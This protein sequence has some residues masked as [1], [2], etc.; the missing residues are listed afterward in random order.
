MNRNTNRQK[1]QHPIKLLARYSILALLLLSFL[2]PLI[3]GLGVIKISAAEDI[4]VY[5][6]GGVIV[7]TQSGTYAIKQTASKPILSITVSGDIDVTLILQDVQIDNTTNTKFSATTAT[8]LFVNGT[9]TSYDTA[10]AAL[11]FG[12]E[13][14]GYQQGTVRETD[15]GSEVI[16][17]EQIGEPD[18]STT[19][20]EGYTQVYKQGNTYYYTQTTTTT[21]TTRYKVQENAA[22][23]VS[24]SR[25]VPTAPLLVTDG[26]TAK[27]QMNGS[28]SFKAGLNKQQCSIVYSK[29]SA[30]EKE[31]EVVETT[32]VTKCYRGGKNQTNLREYSGTV[33]RVTYPQTSS[34]TEENDVGNVTESDVVVGAVTNSTFTAS[35]GSSAYAGIQVD[36]DATLYLS[37]AA[38]SSCYAQGGWFYDGNNNRTDSLLNDSDTRPGGSSQNQSGAAGIGGGAGYNSNNFTSA[39]TVGAAGTLIFES[40][41]FEAR[42]G[43]QAAGI[44]GAVNSPATATSITINGGTV[45]ARGG[46][47][48]AGIGDGDTI[49][50]SSS[51]RG[52][53][54]T[55]ASS[56]DRYTI[57]VNGGTVEA[58]GGVSSAG[59]G[60]SDEISHG[61]GGG[62]TAYSMMEINLMGGHITVRSGYPDNNYTTADVTTL[63]AAI[64][65]GESTNMFN[66]SITVAADAKLDAASFSKYAISNIG[67]N[68]DAVPVVVL[69]SSGRLVLLDFSDQYGEAAEGRIFSLYPAIKVTL[70]DG[71]SHP[72]L[73]I[74]DR[75]Y[76]E[77][78]K[79]SHTFRECI[80]EGTTVTITDKIYVS[81]GTENKY[82]N[83]DDPGDVLIWDDH[84]LA[85]AYDTSD[86]LFTYHV[87]NYFKAIAVTMPS[88]EDVEYNGQYV[89]VI[90]DDDGDISVVVGLDATNQG[91]ISG[92][93]DS[94]KDFSIKLDS[95]STDLT[96]I[97]V[98]A[99]PAAGSIDSQ[100][101]YI[102]DDD[103]ILYGYDLYL[104]AGTTVATIT[105]YL[106]KGTA[107]YISDSGDVNIVNGQ[108]ITI[109]GLTP[110]KEVTVRLRKQD[111][112]ASAIAYAITLHVRTAYELLL[113][114]LDKAYDGNTANVD[115]DAVKLVYPG[116]T[117]EVTEVTLTDD[118]KEELLL[119]YRRGATALDGAPKDVGTYTLDATYFP[120]N[121]PWQ[122]NGSVDFTIRKRE[123][124]IDGI[125]KWFVY[126]T[127]GELADFDQSI[128]DT[129]EIYLT[130]VV[131]GETVGVTLQ[132][133][134][135]DKAVG[136]S[137][138]KIRLTN[139]TLVGDA[140]VIANYTIQPTILVP[141]QIL[142]DMDGA[143]FRGEE[144]MTDWDKFYPV[145]SD[146]ALNYTDPTVSGDYHHAGGQGTHAEYVYIR[147]KNEGNGMS[148]YSVDI[149]FGSMAFTYT[150][151]V[152]DPGKLEYVEDVDSMWIGMDGKN[153]AITVV[154]YSNRQV[155]YKLEIAIDSLHVQIPGM[156]QGITA[157]FYKDNDWLTAI[158]KEEAVTVNAA[159][160]KVGDTAG[161]ASSST[162]Y[163]RLEGIPKLGEDDGR[164]VV[165]S[166]TV[167]I[168]PTVP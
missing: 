149:I 166:F 146:T 20:Q 46:R 59:I 159:V 145:D 129:G 164:Q 65:A 89:L 101:D 62:S 68:A 39:D 74:G 70:E 131:N 7:I 152:W 40:G 82:V 38:H 57:N 26:A 91:V 147:T 156:N 93:V 106:D 8:N 78:I 139:V 17:E 119:T 162:A 4:V 167:T 16:G 50:G 29:T 85:Y 79:P 13:A 151:E 45:I 92:K 5:D 41:N 120:E 168:S 140:A 28:N 142:Y 19:V 99:G 22:V 2:L 100:I 112:S 81:T 32:V 96:D 10:S 58:Y 126:V 158:G 11:Y 36:A 37:G 54:T 125:E 88:P 24:A 148:I 52:M 138:T 118:M 117:T 67:T 123:L 108:T 132:A 66:N 113:P 25:Y 102:P 1:K 80:L 104:P 51:G 76:V 27:I 127:S 124:N 33:N 48:A 75:Y 144:N 134:F 73:K 9:V 135:V 141:G 31:I 64:G 34:S 56:T 121:K 84:V 83:Q 87:P 21:T 18:T 72:V 136:Y 86:P 97:D 128:A 133:T 49:N 115:L 111:G 3:E 98:F 23:S 160:Q 30:T 107:T 109:S 44:G 95:V 114:S 150:K 163:L 77:T 60:T 47:W 130:G 153:N 43:H 61:N 157:G 69:D 63:T 15:N 42:G 143:I 110:E 90:P 35:T 154:N 161:H 53:W 94:E 55:N 116:T 103:I 12:G 105:I 165:G 122:A 155:S 14:L 6:G 71:E 137:S